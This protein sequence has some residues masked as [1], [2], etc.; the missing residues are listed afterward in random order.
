MTRIM[1]ASIMLLLALP[2]SQARSQ[3]DDRSVTI[4]LEGTLTARLD[5]CRQKAE[6][7]GALAT[8]LIDALS[9]SRREVEAL[10]RDLRTL[11]ASVRTLGAADQVSREISSQWFGYDR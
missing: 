11:S 7:A 9:R 10:K 8:D 2:S 4:P 5:I 3:G 6:A 1:V